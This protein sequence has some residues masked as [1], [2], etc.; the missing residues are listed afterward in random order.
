MSSITRQPLSVFLVYDLKTR[1]PRCAHFSIRGHFLHGLIVALLSFVSLGPSDSPSR[2]WRL[3][4]DEY[5]R[6]YSLSFHTE[7][8]NQLTKIAND[9]GMFSIFGLSENTEGVPAH[10]LCCRRGG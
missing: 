5:F 7:F 9:I 4:L 8:I 3:S 10:R 2:G 6:L 1:F